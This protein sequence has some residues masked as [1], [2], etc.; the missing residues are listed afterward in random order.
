MQLGIR[1][2]DV[3]YAPFDELV[4]AIRAQ[5]FSCMHI[6]LSKSIR[7]FTPGI[8]AMTPGLAMHM[9]RVCADNGID[10]AVLGNYLNLCHPDPEQYRAI[11]KKYVAHLRFASILGCGVVGT[12]TG[13]CNAEYRYEPH[14]HSEEALSILIDRLH[15]AVEAAERFGVILAIE[16][17]WKHIVCDPKRAR[18]VLDEIDSPNLQIILDP[19][20][21][22]C[23]D[24]ADRQDDIMREAFE[25]LGDDIAVIHLKD[26]LPDGD[27]LK[28]VESGA[29]GL[30]YPVLL[31]LIKEHKP[32]IHCTMENTKPENAVRAR[33]YVQGIYDSL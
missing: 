9:K 12:E 13:A 30:H 3:A 5:G 21:L 28:S 26:F 1:A 8:R 10:I 4:P 11:L 31:R 16:P 18:R 6:A 25:L 32:Y 14:N 22:L 23:R 17:V 24:N 15:P 27:D 20:N 19:V 33:E 7:E 2:H 29:G